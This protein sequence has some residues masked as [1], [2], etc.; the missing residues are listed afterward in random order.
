MRRWANIKNVSGLELYVCFDD[1]KIYEIA[2]GV[3]DDETYHPLPEK[4]GYL[5]RYLT[6][7]TAVP[8]IPEALKDFDL[9]WATD[10]QMKIYKA[11]AVIPCGTTVTYGELAKQ[12][13]S[14]AY[15]AVG[16]VMS[17]N[18]FLIALPCHRVTASGGKLGG[19]SSG[20][21]NK[22]MLLRAEGINDF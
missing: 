7:H 21:H 15:R 6:D 3:P 22:L 19:F 5:H 1:E 13:G 14:L 18:R 8:F 9:S 4:F 10:F 20:I 16:G 12:A 2:S 17:K 11:L